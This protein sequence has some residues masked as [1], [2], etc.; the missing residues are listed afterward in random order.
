VWV[1]IAHFIMCIYDLH[2]EMLYTGS[3]ITM[4]LDVDEQVRTC[5][6]RAGYMCSVLWNCFRCS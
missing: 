1:N 3:I 6:S 5:D 4:S 2:C